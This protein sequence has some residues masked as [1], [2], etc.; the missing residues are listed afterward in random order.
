[1]IEECLKTE[2]EEELEESI[3]E[4]M[5]DQSACGE[6]ALEKYMKIIQEDQDPKMEDKVLML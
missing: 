1:M 5:K 3:E 4:E 6:N 2:M